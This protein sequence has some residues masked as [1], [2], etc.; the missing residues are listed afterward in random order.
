MFHDLVQRRETLNDSVEIWG[1]VA[2][3]LLT[4]LDLFILDSDFQIGFGCLCV[5]TWQAA[6]KP[7]EKVLANV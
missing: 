2:G 6:K 1:M 4:A 7:P 5:E 3:L